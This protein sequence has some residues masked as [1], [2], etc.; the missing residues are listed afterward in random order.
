L[1][2]IKLNKRLFHCCFCQ[3]LVVLIIQE[4]AAAIRVNA[5]RYISTLG[6]L[7]P[8]RAQISFAHMFGPQPQGGVLWFNPAQPGEQ[9]FFHIGCDGRTRIFSGS[10]CEF[11]SAHG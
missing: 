6:R 11:P 5:R 7:T 8:I 10:I 9:N 1:K 4:Y 2:N 3:W